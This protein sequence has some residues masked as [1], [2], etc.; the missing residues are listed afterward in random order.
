MVL[1]T[2]TAALMLIPDLERM[3]KEVRISHDSDLMPHIMTNNGIL[4]R[5][6]SAMFVIRLDW[7][8]PEVLDTW[9]SIE[10][11]LLWRCFSPFSPSLWSTWNPAKILVPRSRMGTRDNWRMNFTAIIV[12]WLFSFWF[13]KYLILVGIAVGAFFIPEGTFAQGNTT[14][15]VFLNMRYFN[16]VCLFVFL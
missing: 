3:L 11:V 7:T 4:S 12:F 6:T 14:V 1:G 10:S 8:V 9:Q 2:F 15:F 5:V 16:F 13:F